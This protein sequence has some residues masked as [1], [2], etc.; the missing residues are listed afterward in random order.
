[1]V[2]KGYPQLH[3]RTAR[4]KTENIVVEG[5]FF[6]TPAQLM[7]KT[8]HHNPRGKAHNKQKPDKEEVAKTT[9]RHPSSLWGPNGR[10]LFT[11]SQR[12]R[13]EDWVRRN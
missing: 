8:L 2:S 5:V 6:P 13:V 4:G 10:W 3:G 9:F 7:G 11:K 1:L 12:G